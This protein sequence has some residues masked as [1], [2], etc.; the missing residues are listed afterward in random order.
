M[1]DALLSKLDKTDVALVKSHYACQILLN[2][3]AYYFKKL[4]KHGLVIEQEEQVYLEAMMTVPPRIKR[5]RI[6]LVCPDPKKRF[7]WILMGPK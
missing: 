4:K 7:R 2:R 6:V 5:Q 1:A 3:A